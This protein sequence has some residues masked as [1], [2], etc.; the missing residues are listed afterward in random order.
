MVF[1]FKNDLKWIEKGLVIIK[2][3]D[4]VLVIRGS[5]LILMGIIFYDKFVFCGIKG[6]I[7]LI[8]IYE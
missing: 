7:L 6:F 5:C 3:V 1:L 2:Y 8:Y 4:F